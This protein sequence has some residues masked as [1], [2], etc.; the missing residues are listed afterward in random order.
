MKIGLISCSKAKKKYP[1]PAREMYSASNIFRRSLEYAGMVCNKVYI[2]SAKHGLLDLD[3]V[4]KPYDETLTNK[5]VA[6]RKE[7]AEN[8]I[9]EL[10]KKTDLENDEFLILTGKKYHEFLLNDLKNYKLPLEGVSMFNR[11]SKLKELT[12][13]VDDRAAIIHDTVQRMPR[14]S[15]KNIDDIEFENGI[16]L[17]FETG[18]TNKGTDR[19]VRVGT[20]RADNRLK[21]RLRDH[22]LV[23]NKDGSIFRK[24][25]GLAMLNKNQ[26]EFLDVWRLNTSNPEIKKENIDRLN[27]AYKEEIEERVSDYLK[28]NTEFVCIE[29]NSEKERLRI[30]EGLLTILCGNEKFKASDD[31]LGNY[32]PDSEI[33]ESY[34]WNKQG[35]NGKPLFLDEVR[36]LAKKYA[37]M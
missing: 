26:D 23:K 34:L 5:S 27:P 30:E 20:H 14:Y 17:I 24:N 21:R 9:F 36:V 29:V 18:E 2:L 6:E 28:N 8:V 16:Y 33:R 10:N 31:W 4:I 1:C 7:W 37:N 15:W 25:I 11:I 19:I 12:K 13:E 3:S 22:Y 32:H 35:L